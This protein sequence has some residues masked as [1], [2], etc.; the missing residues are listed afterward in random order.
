MRSMMARSAA[1]AS[2]S[3][4][5]AATWGRMRPGR[6]PVQQRLGRGAQPVR[7]A[8]AVVEQRKAERG[9]VLHQQ[10]VRLEDR[11]CPTGEA[12]H[13]MPPAPAERTEAL[14]E[15]RRRRRGRTQRRS[16][17][18]RSRPSR[19]RG[20]TP[21]GRSRPH[22]RAGLWRARISPLVEAAAMT[23]A[24]SALP[25]STAASPVPPPAPS[26]S[27]VSPGPRRASQKS[28]AWAVR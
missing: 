10:V 26:T 14:L 27:R 21:P 7:P 23:R 15:K 2:S 11:N 25:T 24:P 28:P 12:D 16:L 17:G 13:D 3:G 9:A 4:N 18:R 5:S 19:A 8:L 1:G 20:S 22:R 6:G